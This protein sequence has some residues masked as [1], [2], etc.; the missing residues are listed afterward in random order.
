MDFSRPARKR[1]LPLLPNFS[2]NKPA[3]NVALANDCI[4]VRSYR[5][6]RIFADDRLYCVFDYISVFVVNSKSPQSFD[7][8][9]KFDSIGDPHS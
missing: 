2:I 7:L 8:D 1:D 4:I 5:I 9:T 6:K 3:V